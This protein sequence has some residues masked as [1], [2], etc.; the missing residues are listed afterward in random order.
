MFI[1]EPKRIKYR[2][3]GLCFGVESGTEYIKLSS[4]CR[5]SFYL[6]PDEPFLVH[7]QSGKV[8]VLHDLSLLKNLKINCSADTEGV[9]RASFA[10]R[11][12]L[13]HSQSKLISSQTIMIFLSF[14]P[15]IVLE[16]WK[17][18]DR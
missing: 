12:N 14:F 2:Q 18:W 13:K 7:V 5:D 10:I 4:K 16:A 11:I 17:N 15:H 6:A 1:T 3:R 9:L 8:G